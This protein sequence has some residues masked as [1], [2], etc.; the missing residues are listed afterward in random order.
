M[1]AGVPMKA[2]LTTP[3]ENAWVP[4]FR[5]AF[6]ERGIA[7]EVRAPSAVHT[8][9]EPF[10]D[11]VLHGWLRPDNQ[12]WRGAVNI[13]YL[14]R[15]ELY[16]YDLSRIPLHLYD[17]IICVNDWIADQLRA[18]LARRAVDTPP[19]H[20][21]YNGV[22]LDAWTF[23]DR[24]PGK[25]IGMACHIH[26]KKNLP[27]ALQIL[28]LL[29][30]DYQ[31]HIAGAIQD[32]CTLDYLDHLSRSMKRRLVVWDQIPHREMDMWWEQ[33]QY[34]LSTSI[35]EGNPNNVL[36]AMAKGICPVVHRWPGASDQ[37]PEL[38]LFETAEQ[39]AR[40]ITGHSPQLSSTTLRKIVERRFSPA[41]YDRVVDLALQLRGNHDNQTDQPG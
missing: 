11:I 29:P 23:K 40:I 39:A 5:Y 24:S 35:S 9:G 38:H 32:R 6:H 28:A 22:D 13:A 17:A 12:L 31:L 7:M 36:E 8:E 16:G 33:H 18:V 25:S 37:F 34:C 4:L 1:L 26:P 41:N 14:R 27:L 15:Y 2:I 21:I 30:D 19:V 10:P 20:V 3:W